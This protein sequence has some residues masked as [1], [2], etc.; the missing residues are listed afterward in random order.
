MRWL[1]PSSPYESNDDQFHLPAGGGY[2]AYT[3]IYKPIVAAWKAGT[4]A[5]EMAA[6]LVGYAT[7]K[8]QEISSAVQKS[9]GPRLSKVSKELPGI[10]GA[11]EGAASGAK[12]VAISYWE[13]VKSGVEGWRK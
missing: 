6:G 12:R 10:P 1:D 13:R 8:A 4:G 5:K 3:T 11:I 9:V 7:R 2:Y